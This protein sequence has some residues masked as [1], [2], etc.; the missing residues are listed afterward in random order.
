[1][2]R[3]PRVQSDSGYYHVIL[4]GAG[5]QVIFEDDEDRRTFLR[6]LGLS[7]ERAGAKVLSYC[8]MSNHVHLLIDDP[9]NGLSSLMHWLTSTYARHFNERWDHV[10]HVFRSRFSSIP[11]ESDDQ[12]L[13]VVRYIHR[14]PVKAHLTAAADYR[15]SSYHEFTDGGEICHTQDLLDLLGGAD[16]FRSLVDE[17]EGAPYFPRVTKRVPDDDAADAAKAALW[18]VRS[19]DLKGLSPDVRAQHVRS[20]RDAGLSIKQMVRLTGLGR[21]AIEKDL[22]DVC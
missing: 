12:L 5:K 18:P 10:G 11:I 19:N 21:Y 16:G 15:W 17:E 6:L 7:S 22:H 20:L 4:Q 8:L 14:N 9:V 2:P 3:G 1:M 13:N